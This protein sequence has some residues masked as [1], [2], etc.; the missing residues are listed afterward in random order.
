MG[1]ASTPVE[2][3]L[4][5]PDGL[6]IDNLIV[7]VDANEPPVADGSARP[8]AEVLL[9]SGLVEQDSPR[10]ILTVTEPVAY[11]FNESEIKIEPGLGLTI[12]CQLT[13]D[14]PWSPNRRRSSPSP[15]NL[16]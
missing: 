13:Y 8:F 6:G 12:H 3:V 2:H 15:R 7:E 9:K 5:R 16:T 4:L 10:K 14:H 11:R 1:P